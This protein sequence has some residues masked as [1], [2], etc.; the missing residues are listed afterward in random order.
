MMRTHALTALLVFGASAC[1]SRPR[2]PPPPR[3]LSPPPVASVR[4]VP[5]N[6]PKPAAQ[7]DPC[8]PLRPG[9][10]SEDDAP[11]VA[12]TTGR[13]RA[14][15]WLEARGISKTA[16]RAW[17]R[18]R[19]A[20]NLED[21]DADSLFDN[22]DSCETLTVGDKAEDALVCTL[23][24]R[25]SIMRY[26]ATALVVRNKRIAAVLEVG[27]AL[28]AMDWPDARWLD[29]QLT[30][31]RGGLEADLHDRAAPGAVLVPPPSYCREHVARYLACEQARRDGA[32]LDEVCPNVMGPSGTTSFGHHSPTPPQ[33]PMGGDRIEL[34][35]C[36]AALPKLDEL[37]RGS[38]ANDL[39]RA[40][41]RAD[42]AFAIKSCDARGRYVWKEGRFV[43]TR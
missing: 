27:Y 33:S 38:G 40:E 35:G 32:P 18:S 25:T 20:K 14:G 4:P 36:A 9:E 31:A 21:F 28:P 17:V 1:A 7:P 16:F 19:D 30:F 11:S 22:E 26:S 37:V 5:I 39:Y 43:R 29:L 3:E 41:F 34:Q 15:A 13:L 24:V 8:L 10:V 6:A 23:A 12:G 2:P 42:R